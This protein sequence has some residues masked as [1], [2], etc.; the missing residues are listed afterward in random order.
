MH[1]RKRVIIA[2]DHAAVLEALRHVLAPHCDIIAAAVDGEELTRLVVDAI[3]DVV[4]TDI[5][6]PRMN[7]LEAC[8]RIRE[9]Y[10]TVRLVIVSDFFDED[11]TKA[12]LDSGAYAVVRKAD[13]AE[14]L[15]A[16]VTAA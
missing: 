7:G 5:F 14:K 3:P 8:R 13:I 15:V 11:I 16:A 9:R 10:P 12:A 6:M 4:V 1:A 2:D